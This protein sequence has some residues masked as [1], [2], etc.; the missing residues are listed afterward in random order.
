M[1]IPILFENDNIV[2]F[3]KPSGLM[4]HADG[5]SDE[6]TLA[7]YVAEKYPSMINV[8]EPLILEKGTPSE[9]TV[10]RPGI[11]HRLDRDTTGAIM[12]A[13]TQATFQYLKKQFKKHKI[14]KVYRALVHGIIK[15]DTGLIDAP[16]GRSKSDFRLRTVQD[17]HNMDARGTMRDAITRFKVLE[18]F[19][20][21]WDDKPAP[22]SLVEV[23][24]L[25]GRTHQIRTHFKHIRHALL[26][27]TLYGSTKARKGEAFDAD[28]TMLH[29]LSITFHLNE[30]G[31]MTVSA[32]LPADFE[33]ILAKLR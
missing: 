3:N 2:I 26:G 7:D 12:V 28:R 6:Y 24:P 32:P 23:Y 18:R 17:L 22:I 16:I 4:V 19:N 9:T 11:V 14:K 8:G 21:K 20:S 5:R 30:T 15:N 29:A 25:T 33:A 31:D 27:D 13:K 10:Q 1:N